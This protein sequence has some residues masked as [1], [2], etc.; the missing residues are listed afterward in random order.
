MKKWESCS[1]AHIKTKCTIKNMTNIQ[2]TS[3]HTLQSQTMPHFSSLYELVCK[4]CI[5]QW[6]RK[7]KW[8]AGS[9]SF[10]HN[11][12]LRFE[13]LWKCEM[14][15]MRNTSLFC[16]HGVTDT[17]FLLCGHHRYIKLFLNKYLNK[18]PYISVV[19]TS[20]TSCQ[21]VSS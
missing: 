21:S 3:H 10:C 20:F 12:K 11:N 5:I 19:F 8:N 6:N 9:F 13:H 1:I 2:A 4:F 17:Q 15:I 16:I 18:A 14:M 7:R